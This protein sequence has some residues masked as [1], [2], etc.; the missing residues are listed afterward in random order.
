MNLETRTK[1]TEMR[2]SKTSGKKNLEYKQPEL[3]A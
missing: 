2:P 3:N 1:E